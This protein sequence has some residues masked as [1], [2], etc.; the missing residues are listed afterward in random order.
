MLAGLMTFYRYLIRKNNINCYIASNIFLVYKGALRTPSLESGILPGITRAAVLEL[1]AELEIKCFEGNISAEELIAADEAFL[2][3][4]MIEVMPIAAMGCNQIGS[5]QPG[6]I[7]RKLAA[8]YRELVSKE[9][10]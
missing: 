2:T 4:S 10:R 6:V 9:T 5:G 8:A 3:N 7:T 1:A